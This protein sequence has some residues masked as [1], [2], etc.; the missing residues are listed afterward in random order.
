MQRIF[1]C[2]EIR[3]KIKRKFFFYLNSIKY[4]THGLKTNMDYIT[5]GKEKSESKPKRKKK[6]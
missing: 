1:R 6:K 5:A 4:E 3:N 2:F